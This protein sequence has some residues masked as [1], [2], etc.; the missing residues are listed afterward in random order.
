VLFYTL[1][2]SISVNAL[3]LPLGSESFAFSFLA[4]ANAQHKTISP[5]LR[6]Q[7]HMD[8]PLIRYTASCCD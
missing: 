4:A 3:A 7:F 5:R 2:F 6:F 8:F 1:D